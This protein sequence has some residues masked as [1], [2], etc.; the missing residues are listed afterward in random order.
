MVQGN[1]PKFFVSHRSEDRRFCKELCERLTQAFV[2]SPHFWMSY[3]IERGSNWV[4]ALLREIDQADTIIAIASPFSVPFS[5]ENPWINAELGAAWHARKYVLGFHHL[6]LLTQLRL[7]PDRGDPP[8][9][10]TREQLSDLTDSSDVTRAISDL[11]THLFQSRGM[12]IELNPTFDAAAFAGWVKAEDERRGAPYQTIEEIERR[13]DLLFHELAYHDLVIN[14]HTIDLAKRQ[15]SESEVKFY[16]NAE[17]CL[18]ASIKIRKE[19]LKSKN[20]RHLVIGVKGSQTCKTRDVFKLFKICVNDSVVLTSDPS[21]RNPD[22]KEFVWCR[23]G[24][25]LYDL[26]ID[27]YTGD[28]TERFEIIINFWKVAVAELR[29]RFFVAGSWPRGEP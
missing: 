7:N 13:L 23:D 3:E 20:P 8:L 15:T 19:A 5:V 12:G 16:G 29:M 1:R 28:N 10:V 27:L 6:E 26:D 22:D 17:N 21:H 24:F 9:I 25:F 11:R 4:A 14:C 18:E 2:P